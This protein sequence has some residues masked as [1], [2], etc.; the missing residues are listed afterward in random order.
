MT[1]DNRPADD[2]SEVNYSRQDPPN[3]ESNLKS[4]STWTRFLF[5]LVLGAIYMISRA[6]VFAVVILQFFFALLAAKPN[7]KL[8][9][10]GH[11]LGVYTCEIIDYLTYYSDERPFP[12]DKDW[13]DDK[14]D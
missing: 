5:M 12:F 4:R 13:P 2:A 9:A 6:V 1:A 14:E 8:T 11:S 3:I 10:L 7:D